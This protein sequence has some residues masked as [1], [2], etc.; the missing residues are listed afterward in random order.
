MYK[1][2][3]NVI[4]GALS[5]TLLVLVT[6]SSCANEDR[7]QR[8]AAEFVEDMYPDYELVSSQVMGVD[9]D[10]DGYCSVSVRIANDED[11]LV[12]PL[13]CS[14]GWI[15]VFHSGCRAPVAAQGVNR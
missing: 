7:A 9:S 3:T 15:Q 11:D 12:I 4:I 1:Q 13:Q 5:V 10:Q 14:C 8:F 2:D 6:L